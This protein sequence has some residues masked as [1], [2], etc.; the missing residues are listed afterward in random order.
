MIEL[1]DNSY[2]RPE[3]K[4]F[5]ARIWLIC[6]VLG[7]GL[8]LAT[9]QRGVCWQDSGMH[10][11]RVRTGNYSGNLGLALA[12]PLYIAASRVLMHIPVGSLETKMNFFSGLGM[13][14]ALANLAGAACMITRRKWP[15][16]AA[17]AILALCHSVWWLSTITEV[18][19]W[20]VAGLTAELWLLA[21]LIRKPRWRLAVGLAI[22]NGL[23]L[24]LH[25]F[26]LLP[27]PIYAVVII[28]LA[29]RRKLPAWS[30]AAAG[31]AW[32]I[33]AWPYLSMIMD[34]AVRTGDI[35][36]AIRSALV[37]DYGQQVFNVSGASKYLKANAAL[38]SLN[39]VNFLI[40][41]AIVGWIKLRRV[42]GGPT[43]AAIGAITLIQILFVVRYP[44]PDQFTFMLPSLVMLALAAAVGLHVAF[45]A[46]RLWR[47]LAIAAVAISIICPPVFYTVAPA[48]ARKVAPGFTTAERFPF[49][50]E[51]RYW[52]TP[53]KHN[54]RSAELFAAKALAEAGPDGIIWSDST[55]RYPLLLVQQRDGL[56]PGVWVVHPGKPLPNYQANPELF[57]AVLNGR[58]LYV[59]D[60]ENKLLPADKIQLVQNNEVLYRVVW[61][62]R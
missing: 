40:P 46:R 12:H 8:Y 53:W 50:D 61:K 27:L 22:I 34:L 3:A 18:Y 42:A 30:L 14:V 48:L 28:A 36:Y 52:L 26:A 20:S 33:G 21:A 44:V 10:Q 43:A 6:F 1:S 13:A 19:T 56:S 11:W 25:N 7:A 23:G 5:S 29:W 39:F 16:L 47:N 62:D 59:C 9:A 57:R 24:C 15:A 4:V 37:G 60:G 54:E 2:D 55:S 51:A 58:Q 38:M 41:L 32:I 35:A 17:V 49:R 31:A 45:S